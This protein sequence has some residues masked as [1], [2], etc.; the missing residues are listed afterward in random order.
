M[1]AAKETELLSAVNDIGGDTD[2]I[3]QM[4]R[5]V[6]EHHKEEN[7]M[8]SN[9][10]AA[11]LSQNNRNCNNNLWDNPWIY[12]VWMAMFA[13]RGCGGGLFGGGGDCGQAAQTQMLNSLGEIKAGLV[14][15]EMQNNQL[16]NEVG[17]IAQSMGYNKD[18]V[19]AAI[20]QNKDAI[21]NCC[22]Q[23][24]MALCQNGHDTAMQ[25]CNVGNMVQSGTAQVV[26]AIQN[27]CCQTNLNI[28]RTGNNIER[29]IDRTSCNTDKEILGL[30]TAM[31]SQFAQVQFNNQLQTNSI[32][33]AVAAE[34]DKTR[35]LMRQQKFDEVVRERDL[36]YAQLSQNAQTNNLREYMDVKLAQIFG[37]P[38][39]G[40]CGAQ[41]A[42]VGC[43]C[44]IPSAINPNGSQA[45]P[46]YVN[47]TQ[48]TGTATA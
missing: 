13:N 30:G 26:Q 37:Q 43:G 20:A 38:Y 22:S 46:F 6:K 33:A 17:R 45:Y 11:L 18:F 42:R 47:N 14:G 21:C 16:I 34:G 23:L 39:S 32:L 48:T 9:L 15:A 7:T 44:N 40:C 10:A 35:D 3:L 5:S 24:Q 4:L 28:E 1:D 19:T 31:N 12:F 36:A 41:Y 8:D 27:C 29:L 2:C 25:L